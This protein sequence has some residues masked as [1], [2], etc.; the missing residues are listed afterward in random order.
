MEK[1]IPQIYS[2]VLSLMGHDKG[3]LYLVVKVL[4][5]E[6]VLVCDGKVRKTDNP[7][8]KRFKHLKVLK[9]NVLPIDQ[10]P[11]NEKIRQILKEI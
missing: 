9:N 8:K 10:T 7:K 1:Q 2:V 3:R 11:N 5:P 4:D 6:F